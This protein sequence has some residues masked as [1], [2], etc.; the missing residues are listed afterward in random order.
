MKM[1][2]TYLPWL[3]FVATS[4]VA[5][6]YKNA[7]AKREVGVEVPK[8]VS[9]GGKNELKGLAVK[10]RMKGKDAEMRST[11]K[12]EEQPLLAEDVTLTYKP[13]DVPDKN[14][15][16]KKQNEEQKGKSMQPTP[17]GPTPAHRKAMSHFNTK[18][19]GRSNSEGEEGRG[20][21]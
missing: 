9:S 14:S 16:F 21:N 2:H 15:R 3:I 7:E 4:D 18:G 20:K 6:K 17:S 1:K 12:T 19:E 10:T 8:I 11:Q 5:S 13:L